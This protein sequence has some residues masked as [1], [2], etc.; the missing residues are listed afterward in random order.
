MNIFSSCYDASDY[1]S[2]SKLDEVCGSQDECPG[3][4][5]KMCTTLDA[6]GDSC[7]KTINAKNKKGCEKLKNHFDHCAG[8]EAFTECKEDEDC[9]L[10]KLDSV[11][12]DRTKDVDNLDLYIDT[13][14]MS[15]DEFVAFQKSGGEWVLDQKL[16][17]YVYRR[18]LTSASLYNKGA[19]RGLNGMK[20]VETVAIDGGNL[21]GVGKVTDG[22][23]AEHLD[24][25]ADAEFFE[26]VIKDIKIKDGE[27]QAVNVYAPDSRY[28]YRDVSYPW[29]T[30]GRVS[31]TGGGACTGTM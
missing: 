5:S 6:L 24:L 21:D 18:K 19:E 20:N 2:A 4:K 3:L 23:W 27:D 25:R 31:T 10:N 30:V 1:S 13:D 8:K 14:I 22:H 29:S 9:P 16:D 17:A 11:T 15:K 26:E 28:V 7:E 12:T